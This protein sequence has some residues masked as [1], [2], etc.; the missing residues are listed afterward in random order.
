MSFGPRLS[1][2]VAV[3]AL[4]LTSDALAYRN[5]VWIPPWDGNAL[6]SVQRNASAI[7]E[8]NPVWY[9]WNADATIAKN[10]NSE[11]NTWR[12]AMTGSQLVPTI[13]NVVNK[14]FDGGVAATMLA[15]AA[16]REKHAAAVAQLAILNAFDG[17][18]IDYERLPASSRDNFTA[19]V[20]LLA[21]KLHAAGKKL[22]VTV[23]A[24][25]G[26][27]DN[28]SGPGAADWPAIGS[29]AD[30]VKVMAYDFHYSTSDAG[31]ITPLDWLDRVV[32]YAQ[33]SIPNEKIMIGLPWYGYDWGTSGAA[34]PVTY[35][36][37]TS[38]AQSG[39]ITVRH[40]VNGEAT[41]TYLGHTVY[42]QDA[43]S[44]AAKVEM[45]KQK[46]PAIGGFAH[47]AAG[48]EDPAIWNMV[49]GASTSAP[50]PSTGGSGSGSSGASPVSQDFLIAGPTTL[51]VTQGKVVSA[52]FV[53]TPINGFS[54]ASTVSIQP[55]GAFAGTVSLAGS[56]VAAGGTATVRIAPSASAAPGTYRFVIRFA[57]STLAHEQSIDV[58]VAAD[59]SRK[60]AAGH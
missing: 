47:W 1:I 22:S 19:F 51:G 20:S 5:A 54:S 41:F 4:A 6:D 18:D 28:W 10:W 38:M 11:N 55:L 53:L 39:G 57:T 33:S 30:S 36:S 44:Y 17:I 40:D 31:A 13:Q 14:S 29:I 42:F 27:K 50:R 49:R 34:I 25:T 2:V 58:T 60:R 32:S 23:Y 7:T 26:E 45:I 48:A 46:H 52:S 37:A 43:T 35:A 59:A 3:I 16:G 9:S 8:A 56:S 12:A 15:S 24:K 21:G